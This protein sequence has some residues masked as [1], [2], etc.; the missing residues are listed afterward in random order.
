MKIEVKSVKLGSLVI[1]EEKVIHFSEGIPGFPEAK[2]YALIEN[3]KDH[4]F[5]WLQSLDD[6]EL[7]FVVTDPLMFKPDY[8][9]QIPQEILEELEI[10]SAE[11]IAVMAILTIPQEDPLNITA[12]LMAPLVVN[13][14]TRKG[15][16]VVMTDSDYTHREPILSPFIENV[17]KSTMA[18]AG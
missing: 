8:R 9:P 1:D 10:Q 15:K 3:G 14:Q 11:S 7:A 4:P 12:N 13:T 5:F 2:R 6:L 18:E 17:S 16:Q